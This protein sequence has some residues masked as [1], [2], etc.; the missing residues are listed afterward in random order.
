LGIGWV[1]REHVCQKFK[2]G[3]VDIIFF[4]MVKR[5]AGLGHM[6]TVYYLGIRFLFLSLICSMAE[7]K[8]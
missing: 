1:Q 3:I 4:G 7:S 5:S 8:Y 2:L 6:P